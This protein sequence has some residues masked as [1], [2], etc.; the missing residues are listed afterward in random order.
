[1][2]TITPTMATTSRSTFSKTHSRSAPPPTTR[3]ISIIWLRWPCVTQVVANVNVY[4]IISK[5]RS[6]QGS[7]RNGTTMLS[8]ITRSGWATTARYSRLKM[9]V[10]RNNLTTW[11]RSS[12]IVACWGSLPKVRRGIT[13]RPSN[14]SKT[15]LTHSSQSASATFFYQAQSSSFHLMLAT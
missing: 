8:F 12:C 5:T 2:I 7:N 9:V 15:S 14:R 6:K 3:H 10:C 1:M 11:K 13:T 4:P